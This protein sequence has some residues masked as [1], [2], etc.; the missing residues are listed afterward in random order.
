MFRNSFEHWYILSDI[1]PIT[2]HSFKLDK[3]VQD[4]HTHWPFFL[5]FRWE[6][7]FFQWDVCFVVWLWDVCTALKA[8]PTENGRQELRSVCALV[9]FRNL[10]WERIYSWLLIH[11]GLASLILVFCAECVAHGRLQQL[12]SNCKCVG[13]GTEF[14]SYYIPQLLL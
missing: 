11:P 3:N 5:S 6:L 13:K 9:S 1:N 12:E 14:L 8:S 7:S 2:C 4:G 10:V